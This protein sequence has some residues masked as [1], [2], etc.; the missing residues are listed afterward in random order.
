MYHRIP[1]DLLAVIE[2]IVVEHGLELVDVSLRNR[3]GGGRGHLRIFVDAPSGVNVER[4]SALSREVERALDVA[5]AMPGNY[6][7]EV[8]SPGI[9]RRLGREKDFNLHAGE[10]VI[11]RTASPLDGRRNFR[12]ELLGLHDGKVGVNEEGARI[13]VPW[14]EIEEARLDLAASLYPGGVKFDKAR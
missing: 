6:V 7:L 14:D 9:D 4:C 13:D 2:P 10:R 11:I 3:T 12:G 1:K 5:D 8:S